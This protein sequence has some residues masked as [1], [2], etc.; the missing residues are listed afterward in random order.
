VASIEPEQ[1]IRKTVRIALWLVLCLVVLDLLVVGLF[2]RGQAAPSDMSRPQLYIFGGRAIETKLRAMAPFSKANRSALRAGWVDDV[3]GRAERVAGASPGAR[4]ATVYGLSFSNQMG[5]A[6]AA[7]EPGLSLRLVSGPAAPLSHS[8]Y[9]FERDPEA[10]STDIAVVGVLLGQLPA[11][12]AM[13]EGGVTFRLP[14][15]YQHPR[16]RLEDGELVLIEPALRSFA[17]FER[18][19]AV[20][21]VWAGF[22]DQLAAHDDYFDAAVFDARPP[23]RSFV[24]GL[25]RRSWARHRQLE[26]ERGWETDPDSEVLATARAL[27]SRFAEVA[28]AR[29]QR[30]LVVLFNARGHALAE[31]ELAGHLARMGV[32]HVRSTLVCPATDARNFV[33]DGHFTKR[34]N[35]GLARVVAAELERPSR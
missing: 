28:R 20:P 30:S 31:S 12:R 34:C 9:A 7:M 6:L 19:L 23:Q 17:D 24:L 25:A 18:A 10:R 2:D 16:Y 27:L 21:A 14:H 29:Q 13:H 8:V 22:R 1:G 11:L 26:I 4:S 3:Y 33:G 15:A 5:R 32:P 35:E